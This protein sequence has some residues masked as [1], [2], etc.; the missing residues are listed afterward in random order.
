[1]KGPPTSRDMIMS[2]RGSCTYI[3]GIAGWGG[4]HDPSPRTHQRGSDSP[5][6]TNRTRGEDPAMHLRCSCAVWWV[7]GAMEGA[8][9]LTIAYG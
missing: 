2:S 6:I 3:L 5:C 1:M 9:Q 4:M 8:V 7:V